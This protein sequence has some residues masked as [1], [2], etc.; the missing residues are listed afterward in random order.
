[1]TIH[2]PT[3]RTTR[4]RLRGL[5][6]ALALTVGAAAADAAVV[7]L[8]FSGTYNTYGDTVHGLSGPAVP[9]SYI[10]DYDTALEPSPIV[11]PA[12][13]TLPFTNVPTTH[14]WR[15]YS[16]R[17]LLAVQVTFGTRTWYLDNLKAQLH[18]SPQWADLWFDT[19]LEVATPTRAYLV[20]DSAVGS[21][22]G[23]GGLVSIGMYPPFTGDL[24]RE[25][26]ILDSLTGGDGFATGLNISMENLGVFEFAM[27]RSAIYAGGGRSSDALYVLNGTLGQSVASQPITTTNGLFKL[28][29]GLWHTSAAGSPPPCPGDVNGDRM[30]SGADLSVL[31][32][33]FGTTVNPG[34]N[35]DLNVDGVVSGA[36]ISV[37]LSRFGLPC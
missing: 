26:Y 19:D 32:S 27:K 18:S 7:R 34:A 31:L 11:Y 4:G 15:G 10:I 1:M 30:I 25:S 9:F 35:G 29:A 28:N 36:D 21:P 5:S 22:S 16:K 12:G 37:L 3:S 6:L 8:T 33:N 14:A 13:S 20:F 2:D 23:P 17:G 24:S